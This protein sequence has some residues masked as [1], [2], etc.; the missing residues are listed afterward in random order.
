MNDRILV[1]DDEQGIR[2]SLRGVLEDEGFYVETVE[3]GEDCLRILER[4]KFSCVLLDIWLPGMDG[5]S[6]LERI[7]ATY[8]GLAVVMISG[9]GTIEMAVRATRLGAVDFIEKPLHIEKTLSAIRHAIKPLGAPEPTNGKDPAVKDSA[10]RNYQIIGDSV[11]MRALRQQLT[12]AAPT[13]GRV[14]IFGETGTGKELVARALHEE[15]L[16]SAGPFIALNCAAIPEELIES[17]LF[18][19]VRGAFTGATNARRGKFEQAHQGTLFLDEIGDMSLKTQAKVL[20]VLEEQ[21]F[22]PVGGNSTVHVDVRVIAATNKRLDEEIEKGTFRAD[23]FYRL[24]VI[25]FQIPP[26]REHLEDIPA[27]VEHFSRHYAEMYNR[28]TRRFMPEAVEA[29]MRFNWPGNVRELRATVERLIIMVP[30]D[31]IEVEDLPF[32]PNETPAATSFQ[33]ETFREA[34]EAYERE[35][36]QRKLTENNG[37]VSQTAEAI[38]VDRS[39][40]YRRIKSLGISFRG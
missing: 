20:R 28:L 9:H 36:I 22:E 30:R 24:N 7:R 39:H 40:L 2:Q 34:Q 23:L 29:M 35:F 8:P 11:P 38:G 25:P 4:Q 31:S 21:C 10:P 12:L 27:L 13:N 19:H 1:V 3:S 17:E 6:L 5:M 33:F 16:R 26:L 18:G 15:S 14:L 37:N 32:T